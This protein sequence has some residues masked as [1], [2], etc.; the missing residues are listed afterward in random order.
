MRAFL[1]ALVSIFVLACGAPGDPGETVGTHEDPLCVDGVLSLPGPLVVFRA[2]YVR[3]PQPDTRI[4]FT[5]SVPMWLS[6]SEGDFMVWHVQETS[7]PTPPQLV[8][9]LEAVA[10]VNGERLC[11]IDVVLDAVPK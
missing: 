1:L 2:N 9:T 8:Y 10:M 4:A 6:C 5:P 11:P 7:P 3:P